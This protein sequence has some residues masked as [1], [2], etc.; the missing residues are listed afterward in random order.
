MDTPEAVT[1]VTDILDPVMVVP[2][3]V[4]TEIFGVPLNPA[5]VPVILDEVSAI[6]PAEFGKTTVGCPEKEECAGACHLR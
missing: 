3:I 4:P 6:V 1:F 5:D 2:D